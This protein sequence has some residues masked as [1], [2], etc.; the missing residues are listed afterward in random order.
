M[1]N[2][3]IPN[4]NKSFEFSVEHWQ[5]R[6]VLGILRAASVFG[7]VSM[8]FVF[9]DPT[10]STLLRAI[11]VIVYLGLLVITFTPVPY[12]W[13]A[14]FVLAMGYLLGIIELLGGGLVGAARLYLLAFVILA[15]LLISYRIS[16]IALIFATLSYAIAGIAMVTNYY[17]PTLPMAVTGT[18]IDWGTS[19]GTFI[20]I[21]ATINVALQMLQNEFQKAY[22]RGQSM[23]TELDTNRKTLEERVSERTASL[24]KRTAELSAAN[25]VTQ[26][27]AT[28]REVEVLLPLVVHAIAEKYGCYH[29]GVYLLDEKAEYGFL[30]AA[31]SEGGKRMLA[32]QQQINLTAEGILQRCASKRTHQVARDIQAETAKLENPDLSP[33]RA[34]GAFPLIAREHIIGILDIHSTNPDAF[35]QSEVET[36]QIVADQ[37]SLTIDNA[38]LFAD[39]QA[40][41]EQ[42]Q[43]AGDVRAHLSW[44]EMTNRAL[45][46]YQYTP[47]AVQKIGA[48]PERREEAGALSVPIVLRGKNIGKI[49]L[50]RKTGA[51]VWQQQEQS[52]A[53]EVA[54]QVAL[55]LENARLLED[56]QTRA[57]RER[58]FSE[59]AARI[60]AAVDV[61][62]VLRTTAQ[63]IGKALGDSEVT[64]QLQPEGMGS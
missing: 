33:T 16:I 58:S 45:P 60:G 50:R 44:T 28:A 25:A 39:M 11:Y 57:S 13:R 31:S 42:M 5:E 48:A 32:R 41:I 46:V 63:E 19:S 2:A 51:G 1:T 38:R 22:A 29:A 26:S 18:W 24:E 6:F 17:Q 64:I 53:H 14:G 47:L 52:M 4:L 15:N 43:Q 35:Q 20:F 49:H 59:I 10:T 30:Q 21:S 61:E 62:S 9:L 54:A 36:L 55:A 56:A 8:I 12:R 27:I 7:L 34:R 37:L 40:I 3:S 23:L